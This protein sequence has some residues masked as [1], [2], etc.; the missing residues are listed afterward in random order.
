MAAHTVSDDVTVRLTED[1]YQDQFEWAALVNDVAD[2]IGSETSDNTAKDLVKLLLSMAGRDLVK[3]HRLVEVV[4]DRIEMQSTWAATAAAKFYCALLDSIDS[5][6][7]LDVSFGDTLLGERIVIKYI[8]DISGDF[9]NRPDWGTKPI[10]I[11]KLTRNLLDRCSLYGQYASAAGLLAHGLLERMS[12]SVYLF[13]ADNFDIF[14]LF[15]YA[16]VPILDGTE[17]NGNSERVNSMLKALKKADYERT[18]LQHFQIEGLFICLDRSNLYREHDSVSSTPEWV[19]RVESVQK[20]VIRPKVEV[21]LP[22]FATMS[23]WK[24]PSISCMI[25]HASQAMRIDAPRSTQTATLDMFQAMVHSEHL[26]SNKN[27]QTLIEFVFS[28][29]PALDGMAET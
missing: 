27:L 12:Q 16:M 11:L 21:N 8:L 14:A 13:F 15:A 25:Q 10:A 24:H 26:F 1:V 5:D 3:L 23:D 7:E 6:L 19:S 28:V 2:S 17:R 20:M 18:E 22:L 9:V 29:G 4:Q